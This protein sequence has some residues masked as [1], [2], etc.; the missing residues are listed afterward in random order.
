MSTANIIAGSLSVSSNGS[1]SFLTVTA[2]TDAAAVLTADQ[3]LGGFF[4]ITPTADRT[5]TLPTAALL[6]AAIPTPLVI[7]QAI[8]FAVQNNAIGTAATSALL[9]VGVGISAGSMS[10]QQLTIEG[11]LVG[12]A[13]ASGGGSGSFVLVCTNAT[14]PAFTLLRRS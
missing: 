1:L 7:G 9:A 14:T 5:L 2:L 6:A 4:T 10:A 8:E 13:A 12:G 11:A 3:V